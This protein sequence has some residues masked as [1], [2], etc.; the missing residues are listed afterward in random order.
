MILLETKSINLILSQLLKKIAR[1]SRELPKN[2][3]DFNLDQNKTE[4]NT[5]SDTFVLE[6]LIITESK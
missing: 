6:L 1:L 4:L 3:L 5:N 2:S